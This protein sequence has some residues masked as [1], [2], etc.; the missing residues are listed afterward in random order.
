MADA[1]LSALAANTALAWDDI[2]YGVDVSDLSQASTGTS[3]YFTMA[4][5]QSLLGVVPFNDGRIST[6]SGVTVSTTDRSSQ[7]TLYFNGTGIVVKYGTYYVPLVINNQS[8]AVAGTAGQIK[9]VFAYTSDGSTLSLEFSNAWTNSTTRST[10]LAR[11]KFW[12]KTGDETRRY[13]GSVALTGSNITEDSTGTRYIFNADNR[14]VRT[15]AAYYNIATYNL[16][17]TTWRRP[18]GQAATAGTNQVKFLIGL[19]EDA[20]V[21]NVYAAMFGDPTY[22]SSAG[23]SLD[24][25]SGAPAGNMPYGGFYLQ[26]S[27]LYSGFPGIGTHTLDWIEASAGS[28]TV[29]GNQASGYAKSG[30]T[31]Q[32]LA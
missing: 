27:A 10:A 6:E 29:Y 31:G 3:K 18:N 21:A 2:A 17:T 19:S 23:I 15:L 12:Y 7:G 4:V 20:V 28:T 11:N 5:L 1:K 30:L 32:V 8:L 13:I 24:W 14:C 9:D 26:Q 16:N 25:A 22:F